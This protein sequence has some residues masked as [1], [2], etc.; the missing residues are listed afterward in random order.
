[1]CSIKFPGPL[2]CFLLLFTKFRAIANLTNY[3]KN[4]ENFPGSLKYDAKHLASVGN[5][6]ALSIT[7]LSA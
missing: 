5:I 6:L 2:K 7:R 4:L 1:M 3:E